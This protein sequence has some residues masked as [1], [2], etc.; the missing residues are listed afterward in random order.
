ML[1]KQISYFNYTMC[2]EGLH[3]GFFPEQPT[4][5]LPLVTLSPS[6]HLSGTPSCHT[7]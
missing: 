2:E 7:N 3:F 5:Q 1:Q 6:P 4:F